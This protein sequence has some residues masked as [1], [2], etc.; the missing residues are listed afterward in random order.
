M[1]VRPVPIVSA[2][3][4]TDEIVEVPPKLTK[5]P[6]RVNELFVSEAFPILDNVFV[7]PLIDLLVNV[8]VV[9]RP[10]KVSV[11]VGNVIVPVFV[12]VEITGAVNVLLE[13]V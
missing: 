11:D 8:S 7:D 10:T 3:G 5:V 9:A 6:L 12:M 1:P 2:L 13:R 4:A